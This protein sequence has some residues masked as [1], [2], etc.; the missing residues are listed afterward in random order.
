MCVRGVFVIG[1]CVLGVSVCYVCE[2][3]CVCFCS[4]CVWCMCGVCVV[5][6]RVVYICVYVWY[7]LC[8]CVCVV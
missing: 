4:V 1:L 5:N 3:K 2:Y 7:L 8:E 6:V